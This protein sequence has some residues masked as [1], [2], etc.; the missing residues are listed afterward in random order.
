MEINRFNSKN[1][2]NSRFRRFSLRNVTFI[3]VL[4]LILPVLI[5][6]IILPIG[7]VYAVNLTYARRTIST[8]E[9]IPLELRTG[10]VIIRQSDILYDFDNAKQI[11]TF[12]KE[13]YLQKRITQ[14]VILAYNNERA[15]SSSS[16]PFEQFF[17][18][19]PTDAYKIDVS[20]KSIEEACEVINSKFE[21]QKFVLSSYRN[22]LP[23]ISYT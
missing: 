12:V 16:E 2:F 10:V 23:R 5:V 20:T 22:T 13:L 8:P 3:G 15:V 14:I 21:V 19:I 7:L 17:K 1:R 6:L 9:E 11:I 4:K 18:D